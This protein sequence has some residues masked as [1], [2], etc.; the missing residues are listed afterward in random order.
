MR[1][2]KGFTIIEVAVVVAISTLVVAGAY[3]R[4]QMS[5]KTTSLIS[6]PKKTLE[7]TPS[8]MP[9]I[10]PLHTWV[11]YTNTSDKYSVKYPIDLLAEPKAALETKNSTYWEIL[12]NPSKGDVGGHQI[13]FCV[14]DVGSEKDI[15]KS[16]ETG[17]SCIGYYKT[18]D[19]IF[20]SVQVAGLNALSH[21]IGL[22]TDVYQ[23]QLIKDNRLY[24]FAVYLGD[25]KQVDE[26]K[27]TLEQM[28]STLKFL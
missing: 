12:S 8:P 19:I 4:F 25:N 7:V 21:T 6:S 27:A 26:D 28:L 24:D 18:D 17:N 10:N 1:S 16:I 9:T 23:I 15:K 14:S 2:Q 20:Q 11:E 22:G 3:W 13:I 5:P